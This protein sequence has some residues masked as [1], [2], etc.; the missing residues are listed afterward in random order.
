MTISGGTLELPLGSYAADRVAQVIRQV[1]EARAAGRALPDDSSTVD[2]LVPEAAISPV[3]PRLETEQLERG[4]SPAE[5]EICPT[6]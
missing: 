3:R 4:L 5:S 6:P 2:L 1:L